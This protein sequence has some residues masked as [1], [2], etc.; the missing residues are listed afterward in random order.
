MAYPL[1]WSLLLL[2]L[3]TSAFPLLKRSITGPVIT[4]NFPD[5]SFI[6]VGD[7][8]YAFGTNNGV[9]VPWATST[10]FSSWTVQSGSALSSAGSWS[11]GKDLWAPNVVQVVSSN[12]QR[13]TLVGTHR[14]TSANQ[15]N[16]FVMYYSAK[17]SDDSTHCVG[18]ATASTP[19][20]PY[21]P[22]GD[23][24]LACPSSQGGA[25]DAN[26]FQDADGS[27][28]LLYKVRS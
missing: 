7:T 8:Y 26:G 17:L 16:T 21:D 11:S 5:P 18:V 6:E 4:S 10:D 1:L 15:G 2:S 24:P 9:L 23:S 27:L 28:Y 25:I 20:G 3:Q 13:I 22:V 14:L 19:N 12:L